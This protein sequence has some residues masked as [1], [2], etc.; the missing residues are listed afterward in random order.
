M[1]DDTLFQDIF[2]LLRQQS[3]QEGK[4]D[5][6]VQLAERFK[7]SR[8]RVRRVLDRLTDMGVIARAQKRGVTLM[9]YSPNLLASQI[10]D[11]LS[12]ASFDGYE[13]GEARTSTELE[14]LPLAMKRMT[15]VI[16][17]DLE[18]K[19]NRM[20][21]CTEFHGA[22]LKLYF[23]CHRTILNAAGNRILYG[24]AY[25]LALH[26]DRVLQSHLHHDHE[27][28]MQLLN[29]MRELVSYARAGKL[30]AARETL[31]EM[32]ETESSYVVALG[33]EENAD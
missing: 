6:E 28:V 3:R 16:F 29:G 12:I 25:A 14:I 4:V 18:E 8:F 5:T 21:R 22:V 32:L 1:N 2:Q 9:P 33:R 10:Y 23:E 30:E 17:G 20:A 31:R 7:V 26:H 19:L 11:H 24:Y 27:T 15:P 13:I